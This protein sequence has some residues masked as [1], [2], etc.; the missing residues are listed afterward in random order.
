MFLQKMT[1]DRVD[2]WR[3]Q[4]LGQRYYL[5]PLRQMLDE[6]DSENTTPLL[7]GKVSE[8][9]NTY[10]ITIYVFSSCHFISLIFSLTH[11]AVGCPQRT[12]KCSLQSQYQVVQAILVPA[13][14]EIRSA[15]DRLVF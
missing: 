8:I 9:V 6:T 15:S 1:K 5:S 11:C 13:R 2:G 3:D 4:I 10:V 7:P 14:F 12:Y